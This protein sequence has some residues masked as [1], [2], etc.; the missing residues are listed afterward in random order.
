[1]APEDGVIRRALLS[2]LLL[3]VSGCGNGD[4]GGSESCGA[5]S[6]DDHLTDCEEHALGTD[7]QKADT[8]GDTYLDGDEVLEG[9]D[10]LD[11]ESRIYRGNW[12]YQRDKSQIVDPGFEGQAATGARLPHLVAQDQFGELVDLYDYAL[13]GKPVVIDL[14]AVW[15]DA[16]KEMALWLEGKPSS[17]DVNPELAPIVARV[18]NGEIL[19]VTLLFEDRIGNPATLEDA[20]AWAG[21]FPN[22][23]IAVVVDDNRALR[24]WFYPGAMPSVQ[25]LDPNLELIVYDRFDYKTALSKLVK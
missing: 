7:P 24:D 2:A 18:A 20:Q 4:D 6:D 19:W 21:A 25:A 1:M 10:P 12:P 5:D 14:S 8:D 22:S 9:K 15:C 3:V 13:H 23:K 16:C 17:M 11:P